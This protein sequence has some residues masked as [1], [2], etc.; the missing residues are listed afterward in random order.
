MTRPLV[1]LRPEPGLGQTL[2]SARALG[3]PTVAAPLFVVSPVK[4]EAPDSAGFDAIVAGSANAFLHG[5]GQ[6]AGLTRLP[7]YAVG[8]STAKAARAAGFAVANTGT[9][10]LQELLDGQ[11]LPQRLLR[12]A[13][14]RRLPLRTP[15]GGRVSER[16]VYRA[17][18]RPL[19]LS[20]LEVLGAGAVVVLH[21]GEAARHFAAECDRLEVDRRG[22]AL[23]ALAPRV[24]EAAGTGWETVAVAPAT[25]DAALLAMAADMCQT[26]P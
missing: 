20:A 7:V 22:V 3:I 2:A 10:G 17:V 15:P 8:E 25:T 4:W 11:G 14:E 23:A 5:G 26:S 6:L 13:G 9:G 18:S 19:S 16:V 1:V 12:L 24:A 21:S